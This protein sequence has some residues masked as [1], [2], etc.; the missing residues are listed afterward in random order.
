MGTVNCVCTKLSI[1]S[2]LCN[3]YVLNGI[4]VRN[5]VWCFW[6]LSITV[7]NSLLLSLCRKKI[8]MKL[9][10]HWNSQ[11][12]RILKFMGWLAGSMYCLMGGNHLMLI[13]NVSLF[14]VPTTASSYLGELW[15]WSNV[16]AADNSFYYSTVQRW[17]TTAPGA[18]TTHWYQLRCVLPQPL[19][20]MPGQEITGRL[21]MVAHHAQSYTIYLTLAG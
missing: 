8:Y 1:A 11:L 16:F 14:G 19:Y 7:Q 15:I 18:P 13:N 2:I 10:S 21:H 6:C 9:M 20:V 3:L 17:L 4:Y 5:E 12:L